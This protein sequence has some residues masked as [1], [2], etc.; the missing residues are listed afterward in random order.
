LRFPGNKNTLLFLEKDMRAARVVTPVPDRPGAAAVVSKAV[1]RAAASLGLTN[2]GLAKVLG[3]SAASASRLRDGSYILPLDSKPY[4]FA[5]LL[6]RLF[7][8]LDAMM[9]GEEQA[10]QSWMQTPNRALDG[11]PID[12]I[13]SVT[14][15]VETVAYVDA[16]RARV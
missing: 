8:G 2:A 13:T 14:G 5:L 7:R 4:E 15:L 6:I 12:R 1:V 10:S 9:G 16:A 3:L 11:A